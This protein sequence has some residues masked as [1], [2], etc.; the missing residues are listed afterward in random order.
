VDRELA[1]Y[2]DL[3][4]RPLLCGRLWTRAAPRESASFEY[5]P[6]WLERDESFALDPELPLRQGPFHTGRP[7]FR[8][9]T[10][11][12]PDRWGQT[13]LRRAERSRARREKRVPR[14]LAPI[15][16]LTLVDDETRLGALRFKEAHSP[17]EA[18]FL[19]TG[20]RPIPPLV[21]LSKLLAATNRVIDDDD[22]DDDLALLLVPGTSLGGARPKASVR[23]NDG[24]LMIA[25]FPRKDDEWPVTRWEAV[26]LNLAASAGIQVPRFQTVSVLRMPVLILD[27]FDRQ[28]GGRIPFMS[29]MTALSADDGTL[30]SYLELAEA[31]RREG[32]RVTED[33]R[34]LWR[35]MV[36]NVLVSNT[37]DHLRN[38]GLLRDRSGWRLAPAYDLNPSPADVTR[39]AHA[40]AIGEVDA[41][42][43][44][45]AFQVAPSFGLSISAARMI[46]RDV[47][48]AVKRW[49]SVGAKC[50]LTRRELDRMESAFEHEDLE[51][52]VGSGGRS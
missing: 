43:M 34:E 9:F 6:T 42:S 3:G 32:S 23:G 19:S 7:L 38:H 39:R 21:Q 33:L 40:L 1:V 37:D 10:D 51:V 46:A 17:D 45:A 5:D 52:A 26:A 11:P 13:L 25:K 47:A 30:H 8:A 2:A 18:P 24:Q 29:A 20:G 36:F 16:F 12:A 22:S 14:A 35:R 4:G 48:R 44:E 31:L 27:R 28:G 49:R 50:G 41:E 15:D